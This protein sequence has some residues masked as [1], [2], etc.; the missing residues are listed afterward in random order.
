MFARADRGIRGLDDCG[1]NTVVDKGPFMV[2]RGVFWGVLLVF[3]LAG[4]VLFCVRYRGARARFAGIAAYAFF[5]LAAIASLAVL[6]VPLRPGDSLFPWLDNG[7]ALF[8]LWGVL[9]VVAALLALRP[10]PDGKAQRR[11]SIAVLV[12]CISGA[13]LFTLLATLHRIPVSTTRSVSFNVGGVAF[14][15]SVP[16]LLVAAPA[17]LLRHGFTG[18]AWLGFLSLSSIALA[19]LT[20]LARMV[21]DVDMSALAQ[22]LSLA[23]WAGLL[24]FF[25]LGASA[26]EL[27]KR[28]GPRGIERRRTGVAALIGGGLA[29]AYV[30][31]SARHGGWVTHLQLERTGI[32]LTPIAV[33]IAALAMMWGFWCV[34]TAGHHRGSDDAIPAPATTRP[35]NQKDRRLSTLLW[36]VGPAMIL[37]GVFLPDKRGAGLFGTPVGAIKTILVVS[38]AGLILYCS[39]GRRPKQ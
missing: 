14:I 24:V 29:A 4:L 30:L 6:G 36:I 28:F 33:G 32:P 21:A 23:G 12:L 18:R 20:D 15:C 26:S 35:K 34:V 38:G 25:Y 11:E 16:A 8:R 22:A 9:M 39:F 27:D 31:H 5:T 37:V 19:G 17:F 7:R 3:D 10:L 1:R 13:L 2:P